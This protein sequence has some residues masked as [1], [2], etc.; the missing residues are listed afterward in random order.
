MPI[1]DTTRRNVGALVRDGR[2]RR[3]FLGLVSTPAPLPGALAERLGRRR[4]LRVVDVVAGSPADRAGLKP[5]D[6]VLEAGRAPVAEA[7][8][9][10]RL[11]FGEAIGTELPMTVHRRGAMVDV[12]AVPTE[13][14]GG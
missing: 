11:L 1:N 8:S 3:A 7:Q 9:L 2:V 5:G 12:I 14:T 13:L 6:L 4:G 10:S